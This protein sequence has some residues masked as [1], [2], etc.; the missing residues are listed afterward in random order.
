MINLSHSFRLFGRGLSVRRRFANRTR[1]G[2]RNIFCV[3][4][5]DTDVTA[6]LP[7]AGEFSVFRPASANYIDRDSNIPQEI[8]DDLAATLF[9]EFQ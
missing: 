1:R 4:P 6:R 8:Y 3:P 7:P 5:P 2:I 9:E